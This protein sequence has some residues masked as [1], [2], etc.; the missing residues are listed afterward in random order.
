MK[1]IKKT[2]KFMAAAAFLGA[3]VSSCSMDLLPLNEVVL[4]NFYTNKDDVQSLVN[5]C[6]LGMQENGYVRNLIIWGEVRSDNVDNGT[7]VYRDYQDLQNGNIRTTHFFC[8][9]SAMYTVINRC[10]TAIHYAPEVAAKDPNYTESLMK[11][12]IAE[13]KALRAMSYLTLIKTF[14]NVP[15]SFEPSIDDTQDFVIPASS[16]E[17]IVDALIKDLEEVKDDAP[18]K[19][20]KSNGFSSAAQSTGRITRA[21]MY[22]ILAELYLWKASD[23]NLDRGSQQ[24]AYRKC[25]ECCDWVINYKTRQYRNEEF[26]DDYATDL[27]KVVDADVL[28]N[29]GIP[30]L[31]EELGL[32]NTSSGSSS[33]SSSNKKGMA[34]ESIFCNG[35]SFESIFEITYMHSGDEA[36][37]KNTDMSGIYGGYSGS[38]TTNSGIVEGNNNL[39]PSQITATNYD[40]KSLFPVKSDY[41]SL[42]SFI[43]SDG[44]TFPIQKYACNQLPTDFSVGAQWLPTK[45]SR[46]SYWRWNQNY[47][48]WIMYRLTE[49]ILFRAEAE[50]ELAKLITPEAAPE[51]ETSSAATRSI[52]SDGAALTTAEELYDDAFNL[53]RC[54]Y[55]RSNP[56][57]KKQAS[58]APTRSNYTNYETFSTLLMNERQREFLFEGKRYFDLVRQARRVGNTQAFAQAI[59]KKFGGASKAVTV[60]LGMMDFMYLP[61]LKDQVK[62]NPNLIQNSAFQ[63]EEEIVK[64]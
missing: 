15:F 35:N 51:E 57:V 50:I 33:S 2:I 60:K 55:D 38:N 47:C 64:N 61:Y 46:V 44:G 13:C 30:L 17:D 20:I 12:N 37:K 26:E 5:S 25:I 3:T 10:N 28:S 40:D 36:Y 29:Y 31:A 23:A 49:I 11:I 41:R 48:S 39:C 19:N 4:E 62:I 8:N 1:N 18:I 22:S 43:W 63:D 24:A 9:W 14:K 42:T 32:G 56:Y 6:Y 45:Q 52:I 21:A 27:A 59:S 54:V 53:I 16:F 34:F 7:N 58:C